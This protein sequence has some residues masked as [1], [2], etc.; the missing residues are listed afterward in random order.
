MV[1]AAVTG[2]KKVVGIPQQSAD[3]YLA[4]FYIGTSSTAEHKDTWTAP[5]DPNVFP[6]SGAFLHP[7][8]VLRFLFSFFSRHSLIS[9]LHSICSYIPAAELSLLLRR[10]G[11][12]IQG[13][14]CRG[15]RKCLHHAIRTSVHD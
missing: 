10:H 8:F 5:T 7:P 3:D 12:Q 13:W 1:E 2:E 15:L 11:P 6:S 4:L 9:S 14:G